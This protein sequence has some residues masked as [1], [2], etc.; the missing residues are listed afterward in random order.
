MNIK[1]ILRLRNCRVFRDFAWPSD[2]HDFAKYNLIYGWNGSGKTTISRLLRD[3]ELRRQP[4]IGEVTLEGK[5]RAISGIDFPSASI[6]MRVFNRDFVN[7]SVFPTGGGDVPPILILGKENIEKQRQLDAV[8][9]ELL[10]LSRATEEIITQKTNAEAELDKHCVSRGGVIRSLLRSSDSSSYNNYNK[11]DYRRQ[12]QTLLNNGNK[13]KWTLTDSE[14]ESLIAQHQS[15]PR[16][17]ISKTAFSEPDFESLTKRT[18][19]LLS[20]SVVSQTIASLR[21]DV[22][23]GH[24][25]HLGLD[26]HNQ[27]GSS[28]CLFCEQP[29]PG[30][31]LAALEGHFS[32]AYREFMASV[33]QLQHEI[34]SVS[35]TVATAELPNE[36][37][38]Y[39]FLAQDYINIRD[40]I[41]T[42]RKQLNEYMA[43]LTAALSN[44]RNQPF[45]PM[46]LD[47]SRLV[48]PVGSVLTRLDGIIQQHNQACLNHSANV[49][50]AR[51]KL[52]RSH[53][54]ENLEEFESLTTK[55]TALDETL[56]TNRSRQEVLR[57]QSL[58]LETEITE[59]R[60]PAEELNDDLHKYVG[61]KELQLEVKDNGY[62]VT[63]NG[64]PAA[65]LSEGETT[66]IALLY[67]LKSLTDHR[68]DFRNGTVVLD[69][70]VSSL[71]ANSL[72]LAFGFIQ[73]RTRDAGQLVILTH[74]FTFFRQ[75]RSWFHHVKGQR[76]NNVQKRPARFFMLNCLV[77]QDGRYSRI[78]H[79]DPL[80]EEYESDYHYL[81]AC[82]QRGATSGNSDL[83]ANYM[84]PNM[85][86]RL[87]EAFLAFRQPDI[88]GELRQKMDNIEFEEAKKARL[89]RFVHSYSHNDAIEEPDHDPTLLG[90]SSAVLSDLLELMKQEDPNHFD[91]MVK[92]IS[93]ESA[94]EEEQ[95]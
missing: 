36:H 79:L 7:E 81:F 56:K 75:V 90:E 94:D 16:T 73:E 24:W 4:P 54:A 29:L 27:R 80:L 66:A 89:L 17:P 15:A 55:A 48:Q 39:E 50:D 58:S 83:Q 43:E 19:D 1:R 92:L 30:G 23:A 42:Y 62:A 65:Q 25:V 67:F 64:R 86:R 77:D 52:E 78:Q 49:R 57:A 5:Q 93:R 20:T 37:E 2:L 22:E 32:T 6:P 46:N 8:T 95:E 84:L 70:P 38:F 9:A 3:L 44:K 91:R 59:H 34:N 14:R 26:L 41:E 12:A 76:S 74:N 69:D 10:E 35:S 11:S 87:L 47:V 13:T 82:V 40:E 45:D 31:R 71:D 51:Q 68:F 61:H 85:A 60:G 28:R 18:I 33:D 53:V 63:R 88:A 72:F 21:D